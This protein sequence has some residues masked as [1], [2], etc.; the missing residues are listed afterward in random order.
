MA[1]SNGSPWNL[2]GIE[3]NL[4]DKNG[5][6]IGRMGS[7]GDNDVMGCGKYNQLIIWCWVSENDG[8]TPLKQPF[9]EGK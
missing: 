9:F 4:T 7:S 8:L 2:I 6:G 3:W 1:L 5:V